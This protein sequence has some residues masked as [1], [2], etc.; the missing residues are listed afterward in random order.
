MPKFPEP[1]GVAVLRA[2][3]PDIIP[4][5]AG[6]V[7]W[8]VYFR[9]GRHPTT[10]S[11][12]RFVGPANG[13]F[14]HHLIESGPLQLQ[15]RGILYA[16][17]EGPTCLAEVFQDSRVIDT[18]RGEPALVGFVTQASVR[19]LDLTRTFPTRA[20]ASMAINTGAKSR[21]RR[22]A[23]QFYEAYPDHAGILYASSMHG[24]SPAVAL[25]ERAKATAI[26]P[27]R[28]VFHRA[29]S[30]LSIWRILQGVAAEIG[31]ELL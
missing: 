19:L 1:P 13:R 17:L 22:W 2:I 5:E 4:L 3:E 20:G 21:A 15:Q 26:V 31:Y 6:T 12:F 10:W 14:D 9:R 7:L 27:T 16:A 24:N 28:P 25:N 30:D 8:R 11:T 18:I 23:L 29:L